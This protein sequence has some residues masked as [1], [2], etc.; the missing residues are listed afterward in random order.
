MTTL[1]EEYQV[2]GDASE[3]FMKTC[4]LT[5]KRIAED[6]LAHYQ[7]KGFPVKRPERRMTIVAFL[8]ERPFLSSAATCPQRRR[9]RLILFT[10]RELARFVR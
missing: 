7:A 8:D 3:S 1:S 10:D 5:R 6:Y 2:V 4:L 9:M